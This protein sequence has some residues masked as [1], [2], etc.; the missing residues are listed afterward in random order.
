[1]GNLALR[2]LIILRSG[3]HKALSLLV[4]YLQKNVEQKQSS[5]DAHLHQFAVYESS[6][7]R[8]INECHISQQ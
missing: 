4:H 1:M 2:K 8:Y 6:R 5:T 3:S 7:K